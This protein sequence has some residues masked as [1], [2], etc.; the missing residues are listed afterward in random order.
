MKEIG[1][2]TTELLQTELSEIADKW[3]EFG[4]KFLDTN[5]L[6]QIEAE[7]GKSK[8]HYFN[9]LLSHLVDHRSSNDALSWGK[10]VEVVREVGSEELAERLAEKYGEGREW[11]GREGRREGVS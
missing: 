2:I 4:V 1:E 7:I 3:Y 10:V 6:H 11:K 9:E 8:E 5:T